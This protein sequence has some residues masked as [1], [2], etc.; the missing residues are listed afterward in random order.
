LTGT[1]NLTLL[2][3]PSAASQDSRLR[4]SGFGGDLS[5]VPSVTVSGTTKALLAYVSPVGDDG[6]DGDDGDAADA[7]AGG[8]VLA[9]LLQPAMTSR[10]SALRQTATASR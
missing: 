3:G 8:D 2:S 4:E 10:V 1:K 6:D 7:F 5:E 9:A